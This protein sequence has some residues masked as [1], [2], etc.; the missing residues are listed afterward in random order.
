MKEG[1][2]E[3]DRNKSKEYGGLNALKSVYERAHDPGQYMDNPF[4]FPS[5]GVLNASNGPDI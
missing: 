5:I 2:R 3:R 4:P 1:Y